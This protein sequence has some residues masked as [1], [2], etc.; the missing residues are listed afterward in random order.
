MVVNSSHGATRKYNAAFHTACRFT[1][2]DGCGA[3][4][5]RLMAEP[6]GRRVPVAARLA[7]QRHHGA[8]HDAY[9]LA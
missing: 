1:H 4:R 8:R 5:V 7:R 3:I 6:R 2:G 9:F